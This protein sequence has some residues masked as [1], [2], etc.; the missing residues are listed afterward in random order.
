MG[1]TLIDSPITPFSSLEEVKSWIDELE[2]MQRSP[3]V[4]VELSYASNLLKE[5]E[6]SD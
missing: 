5:L 1:I 6:S 4:L 2:K 3:E